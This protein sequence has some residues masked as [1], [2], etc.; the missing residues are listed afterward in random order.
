MSNALIELQNVSLQYRT[1]LHTGSTWRDWFTQRGKA[2]AARTILALDNISLSIEAGARVGLIGHNGAGKTTLCRII[3]GLI[4][5]SSGAITN[6]GTTRCIFNENFALKNTLTGYENGTLI[7]SLLYPREA[8]IDL[9]VREA[10]D[11]AELQDFQHITVDQYS[12]GMRAR[13]VLSIASA[14][15]AD[16]L[17]LDEVF[18]GADSAFRQKIRVRFQ[19]MIDTANVCII[20]SHYPE[21]L[22][23][24]TDTTIVL[25]QGQIAFQG[26]SQQAMDFYLSQL[27]YTTQQP[28]TPSPLTE[29]F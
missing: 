1:R 26:R 21:T 9:L 22:V 23:G 15:S 5:P 24:L 19:K 12:V 7:A 11:F 10:I 20:V 18:T 4:T 16:T 14:I 2:S 28:R 8:N 27:A 3:G 25:S 13:L 6:L 29:T 17:I